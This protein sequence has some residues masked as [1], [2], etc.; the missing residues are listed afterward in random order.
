MS[1]DTMTEPMRWRT[2]RYSWIAILAHAALAR[3]FPRQS[4][5]IRGAFCGTRDR[6]R[7]PAVRVAT[8]RGLVTSCR[9]QSACCSARR[10]ARHAAQRQWLR[11]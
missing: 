3:D 9:C 10:K 11:R 2:P 6:S 8:R 1:R 4:R 7:L 5:G